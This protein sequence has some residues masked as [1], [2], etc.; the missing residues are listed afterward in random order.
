MNP[1][2]ST[3]I[4]ESS[5][6]SCRPRQCRHRQIASIL[7]SGTVENPGRQFYRCP[8]WKDKRA[9]CRYFQWVDEDPATVET[10]PASVLSHYRP[11]N[12]QGRDELEMDNLKN[13]LQD[14]KDE[15]KLLSTGQAVVTDDMKELQ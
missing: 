6:S 8:L 5:G 4:P 10:L 2:S 15:L 14:M 3:S 9:D 12:T 11:P 13:D 1:T 7:I